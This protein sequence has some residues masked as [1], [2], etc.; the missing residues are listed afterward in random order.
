[1][2][3]M[4]LFFLGLL[5]CMLGNVAVAQQMFMKAGN[6]TAN[7]SN[8]DQFRNYVP[9]TSLQFGLTS[10]SLSS[11]PGAGQAP[12]PDF[13][14]IV[15]TKNVDISSNRILQTV[16]TGK[17]IP[18]VEFVSTFTANGQQEIV[19]KIELKNVSITNVASSSV[20]G[21]SGGCPA[22][23]ES[24]SFDY[25]AIRITTYNVG[26]DGSVT[27]NDPFSYD[28]VKLTTNF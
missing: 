8:I 23:A 19:Y 17:L 28:L 6:L 13:K 15:F 9:I 25:S 18:L 20:P 12:R 2:K 14:E 3:K 16:A 1:M 21:C 24:Y 5:L 10:T 7:G 26:N 11:G 27:A 22:V 4:Y